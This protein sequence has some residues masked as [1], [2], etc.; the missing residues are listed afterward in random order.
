MLQRLAGLLYLYMQIF[1]FDIVSVHAC[2]V[3]N[4]MLRIQ[5]K[6]FD[7]HRQAF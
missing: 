7:A 5:L 1:N 4:R 2:F 3:R 6:I